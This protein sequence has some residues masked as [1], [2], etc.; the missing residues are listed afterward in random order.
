VNGYAVTIRE[1]AAK[2]VRKLP[3]NMQRRVTAAAEALSG[4]PRPAGAV[5]LTG[6]R[7]LYR[8]RIGDWRIVYAVDDARR[9]VD[10][11]IVAHRR[12]VYRDL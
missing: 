3:R 11:R 6:Y 4:N 1:S 12:E 9:S 5:K 7:D 2:S 8:I 10:V